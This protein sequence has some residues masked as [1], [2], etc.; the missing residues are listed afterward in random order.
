MGRP[1]GGKT[2]YAGNG[3]GFYNTKKVKSVEWT[4]DGLE[5]SFESLEET[6]YFFQRKAV[7]HN[8]QDFQVVID[9][10]FEAEQFARKARH[11][12]RK[13]INAQRDKELAEQELG[14][15]ENG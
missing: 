10:V 2:A 1:K 12:F 4:L 8:L 6:L 3:N 7:R 14:E 13:I 15:E 5:R 11:N 9:D